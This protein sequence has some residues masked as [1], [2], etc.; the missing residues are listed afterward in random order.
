[1]IAQCK[2]VKLLLLWPLQ[3]CQSYSIITGQ[4]ESPLICDL[5]SLNWLKALNICINWWSCCQIIFI[6]I[7]YWEIL[8]LKEK[9]RYSEHLLYRQ[10]RLVFVCSETVFCA[11][12][13]SYDK[14]FAKN[15]QKYQVWDHITV[16][17]HNYVH[18]IQYSKLT[19]CSLIKYTK[20]FQTST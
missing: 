6:T 15:W 2:R 17:L 19:S 14:G 1:M 16:F 10:S 20:S 18:Y 7:S 8:P 9:K 12:Y 13:N 11:L 3:S 5:W 4:E